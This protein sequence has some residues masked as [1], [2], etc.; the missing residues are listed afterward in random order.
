MAIA[1]LVTITLNPALDMTGGMDK[2]RPGAVNLIAQS[3]I[4]PGGKG[5]NVAKVLSEL[6]ASVT[7]TG[8][9]GDEN[10]DPFVHLFSQN[11]INDQFIRVAG[12]SRINVKLVELDGRVSDLNF[13]GMSVTEKDI[14]LLEET[15]FSLAKDHDIFVIAGSLPQGLSAE[16]VKSWIELLGEKGK[17]VFFDSSND[18][19]TEGLK[20]KPWLVK[21]N[22][23]ELAQWAGHPLENQQALLNAGLALSR[24]GICNVVISRGAEG[25][26]W[27]RDGEVLSSS[28]PKMQVVSTV[29]AG[30]SL[31][32]G[33]CW[34]ELNGWEQEQSLRFATALSA[35]AVTQINVGIDDLEQLNDLQ[36]EINV[37]RLNNDISKKG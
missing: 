5:I 24:T 14:A 25:V 13:P 3:S 12:A 32:A 23:E 31:V 1:K 34:A 28:P 7:V 30:D 27:L 26:L 33:L 17:K 10:Q 19:L 21:P 18:A 2:L 8:F 36:R 9:L 11:A 35:L 20:G 15:V 22:D 37:K 16:T 4:N 29:G 6:G